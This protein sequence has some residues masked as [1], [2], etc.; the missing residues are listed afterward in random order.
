[1]NEFL[2][3]WMIAAK[4]HILLQ[5]I[6]SKLR[7]PII[8]LQKHYHFTSN[9]LLFQLMT[10]SAGKYFVLTRREIKKNTSN[11]KAKKQPFFL[12]AQRL[13]LYVSLFV[14]TDTSFG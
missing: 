11:V 3:C 1:M 14:L 2:T 13:F 6:L 10:P 9:D 8:C 7:I 4:N 5:V 12:L